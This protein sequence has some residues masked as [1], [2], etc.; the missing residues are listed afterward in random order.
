M[1][2]KYSN[3]NQALRDARRYQ[4][5]GALLPD[6]RCEIFGAYIWFFVR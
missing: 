6:I 5:V 4:A 2:A 1:K 3:L